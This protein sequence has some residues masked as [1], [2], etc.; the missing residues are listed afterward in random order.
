MFSNFESPASPI[1]RTSSAH[2]IQNPIHPINRSQLCALVLDIAW[3]HEIG[4]D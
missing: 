4:Y 1:A 2:R 3:P